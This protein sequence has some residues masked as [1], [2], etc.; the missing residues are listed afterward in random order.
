MHRFADTNSDNSADLLIRREQTAALAYQ[1]WKDRG[2]PPGPIDD[3][4]LAAEAEIAKQRG[5]SSNAG[6]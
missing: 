2:C 3:E 6:D 5:D 4:W 1:I